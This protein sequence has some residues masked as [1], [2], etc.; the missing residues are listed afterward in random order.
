MS[1]KRFS[2]CALNVSE[3]LRPVFDMPPRPPPPPPK[4]P[5]PKPPPPPPPRPPPPPPP[6]GPPKPPPGGPPPDPPP[7]PPPLRCG[8]VDPSTLG[9]IPHERETR[10]FTATAAGPLPRF[11]GKT[12]SP[13]SGS[14]FNVPNGVETTF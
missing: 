3:Y 1:L 7:W 2:A 10:R 12:V 6:P 13:A 5:P 14:V 4:P 9:P 11:A 8:P